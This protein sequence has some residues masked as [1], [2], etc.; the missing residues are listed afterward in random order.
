MDKVKRVFILL[1]FVFF[2]T[3][4]VIA[5]ES[6]NTVNLQEIIERALQ[7]NIDLQLAELDLEDAGL[8]YKK[9]QLDNL[10]S[11]SR[12]LELQSE[13]DKI[14]AEEDYQDFRDNLILEVISN[15]INIISINQQLLTAQKEVELEKKRVEEVRAQV[16]VGYK[17]SLE[18]FEQ[19]T[20][21]LEAVNSIEKLKD[22]M[23][24]KLQELKQK[25]AVDSDTRIKLIKLVKP[26]IWSV[27]E[28]DVLAAAKSNNAVVEIKKQEVILAKNELEKAEVSDTSVLDL[29]KKEIILEKAHLELT[30]EVQNLENDVQNKYIQYKQAVKNI[31]IAENFLIQAEGHYKI[32][33]E[34]NKAGLVSKND[35]LSSELSLYEAKN[36]FIESIKNYYI[37]KLNLQEV[38]GLKLEVNLK[39]E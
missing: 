32:I 13:L 10:L 27:T 29:R 24:Q 23:A 7:E 4:S 30:Q 16:K 8:N 37:S 3:S 34:Q 25:I 22:E 12:L 5:V 35:L 6:E 18:L 28:E 33:R 2:C 9:S 39:Y 36:E 21:H 38:M 26:E 15:Y 17:G 19:E 11:S 1:L 31:N 20:D 14:Q